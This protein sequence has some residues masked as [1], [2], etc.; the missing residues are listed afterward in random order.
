MC[1]LDTWG[2]VM[3]LLITVTKST[4]ITVEICVAV[5]EGKPTHCA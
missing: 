1:V 4:K 2:G 3:A 5:T